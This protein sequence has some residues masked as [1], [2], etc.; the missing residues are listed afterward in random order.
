LRENTERPVTIRLGTNSLLGLD[1]ARIPEILHTL[2]T[3]DRNPRGPIPGW[4]GHAAERLTDVICGLPPES[5]RRRDLELG[6]I[7][8]RID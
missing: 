7:S 5:T 2:S 1:P 8:G 3:S 6:A 4:D